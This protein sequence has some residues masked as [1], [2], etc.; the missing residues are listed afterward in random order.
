MVTFKCHKLARPGH[1]SHACAEEVFQLSR[2]GLEKVFLGSV[3]ITGIKKD[4]MG[5]VLNEHC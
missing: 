4:Q 5:D 1:V 2:H 3:G